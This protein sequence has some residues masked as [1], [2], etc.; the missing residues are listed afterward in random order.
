[1]AKK[2]WR[3]AAAL[4]LIL[5]LT[6]LLPGCGSQTS[7]GGA[8]NMANATDMASGNLPAPEARHTEFFTPRQHADVDFSEMGYIPAN[9]EE[10]LAQ[11]DAVRELTADI[12]NYDGVL[13]GFLDACDNRDW[14]ETLSALAEIEY[15]QNP[16]SENAAEN[17]AQSDENSTVV[18]DALY[19]LAKDI[20]NSPCADVILEE[21][22]IDPEILSEY[23]PVTEKELSLMKKSSAL[24]D[25]YW[26]AAARRY[27]AQYR[28]R[29]WDEDALM[30]AAWISD[31]DWYAIYGEIQ[32]QKNAVLGEIFLRMLDLRHQEAELSGYE[33][34]TDYAYESVYARDY[35]PD[36]IQDF[37]QAVKTY[38]APVKAALDQAAWEAS[39][40]AVFE[41]DFSGDIALD[42]IAPYIA[43]L[44][45]EMSEAFAY[46]RRHGLYDSAASETKN[47][48]G[49]TIGLPSYGAAFFYNSP[50]GGAQDVMDTIHEFGH[51]NDA[52]WTLPDWDGM[53]KSIDIAEVHSQA[54]ELLFTRFYP[55]IFGKDSEAVRLQVLNNILGSIV[56]G[57]LFDEL[58]QWAY[59]QSKE[60]GVTLKDLNHK[61]RELCAEYGVI[62]PDDPRDEMYGWTDVPHT[63]ISPL[64]YISYAVSA[65]GAFSFWLE[66]RDDYFAAADRYLEFTA[67]DINY[68]FQDS[69]DAVELESPLTADYLKEVASALNESLNLNLDLAFNS[70]LNFRPVDDI[71]SAA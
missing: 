1:M 34:Y 27:T 69:F 31:D 45:D 3:T 22:A 68:G 64:Y 55:E 46:M 38:I 25:E 12:E 11:M 56:D 42:L 37:Q 35:T 71:S 28:G 62:D 17:R 32:K 16:A 39:D 58:Q 65:A 52:Y 29:E 10:I 24:E 15:D 30:S 14:V 44:S 9:M 13:D 33:N 36:E 66:A 41:K 67:L 61:Y 60:S 6:T 4:I 50:V 2:K 43:A 59:A 48:M 20:L 5:I 63:F 8:D 21:M 19:I 57:A 54:L 53:T 49:Y 70:D 23:E 7:S 51:Y 40:A 47:D 26:A 18:T